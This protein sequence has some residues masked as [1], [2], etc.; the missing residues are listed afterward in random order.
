[1]VKLLKPA[2]IEYAP[3]PLARRL[4]SPPSLAHRK[5]IRDTWAADLK[6]SDP[7]Q[8][9]RWR[10]R[11]EVIEYKDGQMTLQ[12]LSVRPEGEGLPTRL[13]GVILAHTAVGPQEGKR[14]YRYYR[15]MHASEL[16]ETPAAIFCHSVPKYKDCFI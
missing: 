6:Q 5:V 11:R 10:I 12:G 13:P 3:P 1:M 8:A 4:L 2:A 9:N 14:Q 7:S 16:V 15:C